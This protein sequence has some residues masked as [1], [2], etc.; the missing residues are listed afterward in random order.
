LSL[1]RTEKDQAKV[2][3]ILDEV[4]PNQQKIVPD[5]YWGSLADFEI[6]YDLLNLACEAIAMRLKR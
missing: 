2:K 1:A 5:P 3:L 4:F 6:T